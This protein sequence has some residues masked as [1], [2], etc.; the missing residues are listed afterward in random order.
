MAR[1][2]HRLLSLALGLFAVACAHATLDEC[3][4]SN[5]CSRGLVC[6]DGRCRST[7]ASDA[8]LAADACTASCASPPSGCWLEPG[9]DPCACGVLRCPVDAGGDPDGGAGS[10]DAATAD[11]GSAIP[12]AD[13]ASCDAT[14]YCDRPACAEV[15]T[16]RPR[17]TDC[18]VSDPAPA[19]G[20]DGRWYASPCDAALAGVAGVA[21]AASCD[22]PC[23]PGESACGPGEVCALAGCDATEGVCAPRPPCDEDLRD[24]VC[25]CDGVTYRNEC[26]RSEAGAALD[27]P[28]PCGASCGEPPAGCCYADWDC[29]DGARCLRGGCDV[30]GRVE[31]GVCAVSLAAGHCWST[32]DC[33]AG[34]VCTGATVPT[35]GG[36]APTA[37]R[38]GPPV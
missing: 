25:G 15:G 32:S 8:G 38:C 26:A 13:D 3:E 4:S 11:A 10:A 16:C 28:G 29:P 18:A 2:T 23:R 33:G 5:E 22:T 34:E 30:G 17:P 36:G 21:D 35:C 20:C 19:C 31:A 9:E 37:G 7:L 6:L 14:D 24:P 1:M 12:C 27:H